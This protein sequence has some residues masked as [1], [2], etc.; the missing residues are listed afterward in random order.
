MKEMENWREEWQHV[1]PLFP[2]HLAEECSIFI[3][4]N[5]RYLRFLVSGSRFQFVYKGY[6]KLSRKACLYSAGYKKGD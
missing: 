3:S 2:A 6:L 5:Q 4:E 1:M